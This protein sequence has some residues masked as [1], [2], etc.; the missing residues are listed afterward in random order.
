M[1]ASETR[2]VTGGS[3]MSPSRR[4]TSLSTP[5]ASARSRA[6]SSIPREPSTPITRMPAFATGTAIRPVPQASS[7]T[8]PPEARASST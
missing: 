6:T 7:T 2:S 5:A 4:S 1:S 8:G 3:R